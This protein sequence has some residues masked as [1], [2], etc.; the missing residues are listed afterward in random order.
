MTPEVMKDTTIKEVVIIT[1]EEVVAINVDVAISAII[2]LR[3]LE[4]TVASRK[5]IKL[6]LKCLLATLPEMKRVV[7]LLLSKQM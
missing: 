5:H 2:D 7:H 4:K 1:I 6:P 3:R